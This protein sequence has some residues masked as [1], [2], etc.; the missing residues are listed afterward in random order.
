MKKGSKSK[1]DFLDSN[2]LSSV[3]IFLQFHVSISAWQFFKINILINL[4]LVDVFIYV[5][6]SSS[7]H[8]YKHILIQVDKTTWTRTRCSY[9]MEANILYLY[10][11]NC[12]FVL[13]FSYY[14]NYILH[15][16]L[17]LITLIIILIY[18]ILPYKR[19]IID[20]H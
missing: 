1:R 5:V 4:V 10:Y 13:R 15:L 8:R 12:T 7:F 6:G 9:H 19:K 2:K 14:I 16:P 3:Y 20:C 17:H 11:H 18:L